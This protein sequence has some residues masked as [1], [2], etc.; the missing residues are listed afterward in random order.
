MRKRK[1]ITGGMRGQE[2]LGGEAQSNGEGIMNTEKLN[3][4]QRER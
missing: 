4:R 1:E 2:E 3:R